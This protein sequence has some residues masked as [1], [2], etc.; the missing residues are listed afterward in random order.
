MSGVGGIRENVGPGESEASEFAIEQCKHRPCG[1][2]APNRM[3]DDRI[4]GEMLWHIA[5]G[6]LPGPGA[7]AARG[8]HVDA[9]RAVVQRAGDVHGGE[10]AAENGDR[11]LIT[12]AGPQATEG[13]GLDDVVKFPGWR[14]RHTPGATTA[15]SAGGSSAVSP[16][17]V[18][19]S[20]WGLTDV[21][22][23]G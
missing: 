11:T 3:R 4:F 23:I 10:T 8:E 15:I 7:G 19:P 22:C 9:R 2:L 21:A 20:L 6:P 14:G 1:E 16:T 18:R 17:T 5:L 12:E 13:V